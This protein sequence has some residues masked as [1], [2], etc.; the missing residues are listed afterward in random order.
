MQEYCAVRDSVYIYCL[1]IYAYMYIAMYRK[2]AFG[3][4]YNAH[5]CYLARARTSRLADSPLAFSL[6]VSLFLSATIIAREYN[7]IGVCY[8]ATRARVYNPRP[9]DYTAATY[10]ARCNIYTRKRYSR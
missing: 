4:T 8:Y 6:S 3:R 1:Y 2:P 7:W 5:Y 10:R 9:G